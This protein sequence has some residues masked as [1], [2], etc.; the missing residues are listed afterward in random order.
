MEKN[1]LEKYRMSVSFKLKKIDYFRQNASIKI[2]IYTNLDRRTSGECS[3]GPN[4]D[5]SRGVPVYLAPEVN[6]QSYNALV[7]AFR[8]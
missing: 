1:D 8:M 3:I 5:F 4:E 2:E 6:Y 7:M